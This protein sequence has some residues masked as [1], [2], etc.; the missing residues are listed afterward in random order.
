MMGLRKRNDNE[1]PQKS[2]GSILKSIFL[3]LFGLIQLY[4]LVWLV[5]FS[6]KNNDEIFGGNVVGLPRKFLW[7]NYEQAIVKGYVGTYFINSVIVTFSSILL[8]AILASMVAYAITRMKWRLSKTV[9][10]IF[11]LGLMIPI[12]AALL[13]LFNILSSLKLLNTYAALIIPYV[14]FGL[15]MAI[16]ILTSFLKSLPRELEEAA[17]L[18]GCNIYKTFFKIIL[19]LLV[20]ALATIS[21]F[22]YLAS[23]NELM[24]AAT[25][26]SKREFRTLTVGIMAMSG[27]FVTEWGPIGAGLVVASFPTIIIYLILSKQVQRSL[28]AGAVKG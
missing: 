1:T 3:A 18:D 15:P 22:V 17:C 25:F 5:L 19:P 10:V 13:P 4:P 26:I 8:V 21:I 16:F 27:Q 28:V 9:L 12:H 11:L 24:F 14:G 23:W 2:I 6:L 7:Q 20:P